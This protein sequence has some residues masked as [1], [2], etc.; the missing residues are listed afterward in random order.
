MARWRKTRGSALE[1]NELELKV[2]EKEDAKAQPE[3]GT[4]EGLKLT[5]SADNGSESFSACG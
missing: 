1:S 2:R 5:L 4:V 3:G